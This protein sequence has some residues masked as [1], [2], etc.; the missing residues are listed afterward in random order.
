MLKELKHIYRFLYKTPKQDKRI[1][2]YSEHEGYWPN[3]EG[4]INSL[5]QDY[6]AKISYITSDINDPILTKNNPNIHTFY[7]NKFLAFVMQF[8]DC[9]VFIMT[10]T[11]LHQYHLKRSTKPVHYV[12]VYHSLVSTHMMYHE[13][14]FD[15]YDS[16]LCVGDYQIKEIRQREKMLEHPPKQLINAGYYRLDRIMQEYQKREPSYQNQKTI[17]IAPSWGDQN[18]LETCGHELVQTLLK[19]NHNVIVRPHPE[20]VRRSKQLIESL[21]T[22]FGQQENFTLELSVAN[23]D[24]ILNADCLICDCSGIA[25]EYAFG[26]ERPVLFIDVPIKIKNKHYQQL[27]MEPFELSIRQTIGKVIATSDINKIS[28]IIQELISSEQPF[29]EKIKQLRNN[30]IF[31]INNASKTG[32][33]HIINLIQ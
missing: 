2:F 30:T 14:A 25:L 24:S 13:G 4:M 6:Q 16:I 27:E 3:F 10:L 29:K 9:S 8:I 1:V 18:V 28:T 17:L 12:Y 22:S 7:I 5:I 32:A 31:E 15:H 33:N 23:D 20:T 21:K 19:D 26:T 11:G